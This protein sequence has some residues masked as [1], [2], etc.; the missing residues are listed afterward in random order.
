MEQEEDIKKLE[1][2]VKKIRD[3]QVRRTQETDALAAMQFTKQLNEVMRMR[4]VLEH[5]IAKRDRN[6]LDIEVGITDADAAAAQ[7]TPDA[8]DVYT[9]S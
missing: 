3:L 8:R 9:I 6:T 5:R 2:M 4:E 1:A 7:G